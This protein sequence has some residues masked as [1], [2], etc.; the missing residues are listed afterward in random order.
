M[1]VITL[2]SK[3]WDQ[4]VLGIVC[5]RLVEKYNRP[6]FL[7]SLVGDELHGSGRSINDINIHELLSSMQD[8]LDTFGGHTMAAGLTIKRANYEDFVK[9]FNAFVFEHVNEKVF[10]PIKYYDLEVSPE[11]FTEQFL[12]E[13]SLLEP[14]GCQNP[15]PRF[16][17]ATQDVA[18]APLKRFPEHATLNV[19]DLELTYF[20]F[21]KNNANLRFSRYKNF[22]FELQSKEKKGIICE[23]DSGSFI[24]PDANQYVSAIEIEQLLYEKKCDVKYSLYQPSQLL[25]F[26]SSTQSS[27]FGTAFVTFSGYDYVD[28]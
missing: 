24:T 11:D 13:L 5:S 15:K 22:I 7:F 2:A 25:E 6:V 19:N 4:G 1:R 3:S 8:I 18:I 12:S 20:N 26:V 27:V 17:I 21:T 28:F 9:R 10:E 16:K 14:F 23:F